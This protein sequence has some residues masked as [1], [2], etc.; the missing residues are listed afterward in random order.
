MTD[1]RAAA[2]R[3]AKEFGAAPPP[4]PKGPFELILWE[5]VAYLADD[6]RRREAFDLLKAE[7]GTKPAEILKAPER[8]LLAVAARGIVPET[9]AKKLR[10]AARIAVDTFGGDLRHVVR[11]PQAD[12]KR[13]LRKFP[14]IG[15]PAAEKI[16]L[17]LKLHAFLAPDS[18]ALRVMVRLGVSPEKKSYGPMYAAARA[19]AAEQLGDDLDLVYAAHVHLR[20]LGQETCKRTKPACPRCP[21]RSMCAFA[22]GT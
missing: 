5:N 17:F 20:R 8:T 6:E 9:F 12:A 10:D 16:L 3:L 13:A 1:L 22:A 15:E 21:L 18:N 14:G 7:V 2:R 19:V 4:F 11:G